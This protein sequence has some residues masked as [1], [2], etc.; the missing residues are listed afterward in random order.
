MGLGILSDHALDSVPGTALVLA[1]DEQQRRVE[2]DV[3]RG[4]RALK[5]DK[6]GKILLVPQPSDDPNDPLVR[7]YLLYTVYLYALPFFK[8][9]LLPYSLHPFPYTKTVL[10]YRWIGYLA[11]HINDV[12]LEYPPPRHSYVPPLPNR[13]LRLD[14]LPPPRREHRLPRPLFRPRPHLHGPADRLPPP[15]R[16]PR[17]ALI[18]PQRPHLGKAPHLLTRYGPSHRRQRMG[19]RNGAAVYVFLARESASG[20]G[21]RAVRGAG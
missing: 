16:R 20:R 15:R 6:T 4:Q 21:A 12:E 13:H 17:R 19:R 7:N 2:H 18:R 9:Q 5:Y 1:S 10:I 11:N 14:P 3:A 8:S